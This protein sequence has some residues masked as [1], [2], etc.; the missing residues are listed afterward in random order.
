MNIHQLRQIFNDLV[1][2]PVP[3]PTSRAAPDGSLLIGK[4]QQDIII[5]R[6]KILFM[7]DYSQSSPI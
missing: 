1:M 6:M 4:S 2:F 5:N 3:G 7:Y